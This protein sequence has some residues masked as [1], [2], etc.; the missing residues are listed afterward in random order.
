MAIRGMSAA[1]TRQVWVLAA[2]LAQ[3]TPVM[4]QEKDLGTGAPSEVIYIVD[5]SSGQPIE[6]AR[7]TLMRESG[8]DDKWVTVTRALTDADGVCALPLSSDDIL[9]MRAIG[10]APAWLRWRRLE[11]ECWGLP[12]GPSFGPVI[13][14]EEGP[15]LQVRL[16]PS[17]W[18]YM[19]THAEG[20]RRT[21]SLGPSSRPITGPKLGPCGSPQHSPSRRR[22]RSQA[23]ANPMARIS[24]MSSEDRGSAQTPS[25]SVSARVTVT[26]LSSSP[27]S[28]IR[29][30]RAPSM[31]WPELRST[32]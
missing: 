9:E 28:R 20:S 21:C 11:G 13:G 12:Q 5:R 23:G 7:V 16:E 32:M 2:V 30:T 25:A 27:L 29:V 14:R 4:A 1:T 19:Y 31:G 18:V 6:G 3:A 17:A 15:R 10:F 22:H 26:H 24:R 8:E